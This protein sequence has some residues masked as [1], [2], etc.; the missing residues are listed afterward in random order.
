LKLTPL[1]EILQ[2][3]EDKPDLKKISIGEVRILEKITFANGK[4]K[5]RNKH[6]TNTNMILIKP[7]DLVISGIN[8]SKGAIAIYDDNEKNDI[9]ATIHYSSYIPNSKKVNVKYLWWFFRTDIFKKILKNSV[10]GGIKSELKSKKFLPISIPLPDK[11]IQ[12]KIL[13]KIEFYNKKCENLIQLNH[14]I[15]DTIYELKFAFLENSRKELLKKYDTKQL[16][17][18]TKVTAGST[19]S[20]SNLSYWNGT[21]PWIKTGELQDDKITNSEEKITQKGFDN[22]SVKLYPKET[23]LIALYGQGKTRGKTSRLGIESTSNQACCAVYPSE[24]YLPKFIQYWLRS[25]YRE[26]REITRTGPQP[27][28][29]STMIKQLEIPIFDKDL[30]QDI[31]TNFDFLLKKISKL[32]IFQK[33]VDENIKNIMPSI[34]EKL[35]PRD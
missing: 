6:E 2:V 12:D 18:I 25:L 16:G 23:I 9:S 26:M 22:S 30:Q 15:L 3:R 24:D 32:N 28:W 19:P 11:P 1:S 29:N 8:A 20:R 21:I 27:N 33:E 34:L 7:G 10:P 35:F 13:K 31:V 17:K 14:T 5:L 4:I